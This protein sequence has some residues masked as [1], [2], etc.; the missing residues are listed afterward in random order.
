[1]MKKFFIGFTA[2]FVL[3]S[4][5]FMTRGSGLSYDVPGYVEKREVSL[6]FLVPGRIN[7]VYIDEGECAQPAQVIATLDSSLYLYEAQQ[8]SADLRDKEAQLLFANNELERQINLQFSQTNTPRDYEQAQSMAARA[9]ASC[10]LAQA[11]LNEAN[12]HLEQT[13][14]V[15]PAVG[16]ITRRLLEPGSIVSNNAVVTLALENPVWVRAYAEQQ[17]LTYCTPG[18]TV[19]VYTDEGAVYTG[20]IGYISPQA[21]FTPKTIHTVDLRPQLVYRLRVVLNEETSNLRQGVAVT[22]A[23]PKS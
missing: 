7:A 21:E 20:Q 15:S 6:G 10:D 8:A 1:M 16:V 12:Y 2:F 23:L 5:L 17:Q 13:I 4:I 18:R 11:R 19:E 9:Q 22:V 14:L 3:V